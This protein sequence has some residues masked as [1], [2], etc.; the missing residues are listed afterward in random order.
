MVGGLRSRQKNGIIY[1]RIFLV[2]ILF[3]GVGALVLLRPIGKQMSINSREY[4]PSAITRDSFSFSLFAEE[5]YRHAVPGRGQEHPILIE[6]NWTL[7][8]IFPAGSKLSDFDLFINKVVKWEIENTDHTIERILDKPRYKLQKIYN[9]K[10]M[11]YL[12]RYK[13]QIS[14]D[15]VGLSISREILKYANFEFQIKIHEEK[16]IIKYINVELITGL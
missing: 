5:F 13:F 15:V 9:K 6:M 3:A 1:Q 12:Y 16:N 8:N 4:N 14:E 10:E 11:Y 7:K 2:L